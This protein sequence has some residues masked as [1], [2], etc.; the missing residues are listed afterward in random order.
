MTNLGWTRFGKA[1]VEPQGRIYFAGTET[2][3]AWPGYFNGAIESGQR[4]AREVKL[5]YV[6]SSASTPSLTATKNIPEEPVTVAVVASSD[7]S[8]RMVR[9]SFSPDE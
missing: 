2:S 8:L 5:D 7:G 6:G 9:H 1:L 4:A 3:T